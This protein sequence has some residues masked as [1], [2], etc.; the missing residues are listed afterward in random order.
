M[1]IIASPSCQRLEKTMGLILE[2]DPALRRA[3]NG[4]DLSIGPATEDRFAVPLAAQDCVFIGDSAWIEGKDVDAA[5]EALFQVDPSRVQVRPRYNSNTHRWKL[6]FRPMLGDSLGDALDPIAGQLFSPWNI[7]YLARVFKEPLSYSNI[8]QVVSY[9]AGSNP[10]AEIFTLF[11]EQYSGWAMVGN[12]GSLQNNMTSD[13]NV[14]DG[15][16]SA[17]VINLSGTYSLTLEEQVRGNVSPFGQSPMTRKQLYLNYAINMLKAVIGY[18]GNEETGTLGLLDVN[19]INIWTTGESIKDILNGTSTS[20]GSDMYKLLA[21]RI[22]AM[23]TMSDNKFDELV[24]VMSPEGL[25]YLRSTPYSDVYD[26]TAAMEIFLQNYG[27]VTKD[28]RA[29]RI[30]FV[31]E[32]LLKANSIFNPSSSDY[33]I[34]AAPTVGGGP[35]NEKQPT[36]VYGAPLQKFVFP[37]I[38]GQYNTQYKTLARVAGVLAP[39]P[40]AIQVYSGLAVQ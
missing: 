40:A 36:I 19:P 27:A 14:K 17:P 37:A 39:V 13:V 8:D 29:P 18:Y 15:L 24:I 31:S 5:T 2:R 23:L 34:I 10:W 9:E 4:C 32:P 26:P 28:G 20:K 16:M 21:E 22:N 1:N 3:L 12:T 6:E 11:M 30:K 35:T 25:N 33:T 7:S 38:P